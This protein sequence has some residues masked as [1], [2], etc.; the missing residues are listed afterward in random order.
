MNYKIIA[1]LCALSFGVMQQ[2][3]AIEVAGKKLEVYGKAHLSIDNA[4]TDVPSINNDG[5]SVS[6]NSSRLGFKGELPAGNLKFIF[7]YEQEVFIDEAAG[8]LG[9]RNTYAGLK[10]KYGQI[11]AGHHDTPYKIVASKWGLFGDSVGER[12]AILGAGYQSG[13]Q[14]NERARNA[15]MYQFKNKSLKILLMHAVDPETAQDGKYD[16]TK[17]SVTS[18]GLFY[19]TGPVWFALSNEQWKKHSKMDT[20]SA[21]RVA[22]KY[23]ISSGFKLGL[24]YESINSDTVDEWKRD[25][26]GI[27]AIYKIS[28]S[29]DI[30]AQYLKVNSAKNTSN[31]GATKIAF[32]VFH[33]LDKKAQ[34]YFAYG[35][36]NNDS[37]AKFQAADGGHGDEIK[38][39]NGRDPSAMSLG[40]IYKF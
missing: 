35:A 2:A 11:F 40:L 24:I 39:V 34:V 4:D 9:S 6:S 12:R 1:V 18:V 37:G 7:Q 8:V 29:V 33:T 3:N 38:T 21:L 25:A 30:R 13:N 31:T 36:T 16:D 26:S 20:G 17:K 15:I 22:A 28:N 14:L 27:N 19:K 5:L 10:G 32:G 23:K